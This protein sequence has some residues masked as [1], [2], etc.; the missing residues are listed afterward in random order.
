MP[1]FSRVKQR[2]ETAL[3]DRLEAVR[4]RGELEI[5]QVE[6]LLEQLH[7]ALDEIERGFKPGP[8]RKLALK[9]IRRGVTEL[10][11]FLLPQRA[12]AFKILGGHRMNSLKELKERF[13]RLARQYHPDLPTGDESKMQELNRAWET[14]KRI[15]G[16]SF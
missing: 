5:R 12:E 9:G 15:K 8:W 6:M 1:L 13:H 14:V 10:E 7:A 3:M 4:P 16:T 2:V 11:M